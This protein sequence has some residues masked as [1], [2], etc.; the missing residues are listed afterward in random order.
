[1]REELH[2]K[3]CAEALGIPF[4]KKSYLAWGKDP[5]HVERR[6]IEG[7]FGKVFS[8]VEIVGK[9]WLEVRQPAVTHTVAVTSLPPVLKPRNI[10][11]LESWKRAGLKV[12]S[13]N[14][15][16]EAERIGT[17]VVDE[18]AIC[19]DLPSEF[20]K[21]TQYIHN[22]LHLASEFGKSVLLI[23][24]DIE[25]LGSNEILRELEP[26]EVVVGIRTN[27]TGDYQKPA[28]ELWGLDVFYMSNEIARNAPKAVYAIGVPFWDYWFPWV[29]Q[30]ERRRLDWI[31]APV[32]WHERHPVAWTQEDWFKGREW[33]EE[34]YDLSIN[35]E[36]WRKRQ[37]FP[38]RRGATANTEN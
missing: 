36:M 12:I 25:I 5:Y 6:R 23:N 26:D 7:V 15:T 3:A 17:G 11:A 38:P 27:Y 16:G 31:G 8:H 1:M 24:S 29:L 21:K 34:T 10:K 20:E 28:L 35:W 32:F 19:D 13:V 30:K 4:S 14:S 9:S 18:F 22:M 37:P 2:V 33:F